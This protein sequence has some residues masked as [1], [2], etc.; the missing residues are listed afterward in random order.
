M[1]APGTPQR[2]FSF[3]S[4]SSIKV[5]WTPVFTSDLP[6]TGY[7]LEMDDGFGGLFTEIYDGRQNT[8]TLSYIVSN[9]VP[10]KFYRF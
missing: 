10:Q 5:K 2:D 4:E 3:M 9:L 8:Q 1:T 7:S 6:V